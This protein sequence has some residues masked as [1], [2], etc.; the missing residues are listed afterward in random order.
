M[1]QEERF[2][3]YASGLVGYK[4]FL[5]SAAGAGLAQ[6]RTRPI[7]WGGGV[8]GYGRR[9]ANVYGTRVVRSTIEYGT[10][11]ILH[12][13][14]R[15]FASEKQGFWPRTT[16]ALGS[17]FL[18]RRD[19]GTRRVSISRFAGAAGG[20]FISR[21]W[22]PPSV[23]TAGDGAISFGVNMGSNMFFNMIREFWPDVK[24][25]IKRH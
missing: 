9:L 8:D 16:Y 19:N 2:Q 24:R 20:A 22:Q 6:T 25:K 4:S 15:Y 7:E 17:T 13:D 1:T 18:A 10:A 3:R 5:G 11:A 23:A 21:T 14:N 12:E